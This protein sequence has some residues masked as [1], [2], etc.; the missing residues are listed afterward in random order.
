ME[1]LSHV[2]RHK[3]WTVMLAA[4]ANSPRSFRKHSAQQHEKPPAFTSPHR[5]EQR[6]ICNLGQEGYS[7]PFGKCCKF[8][9]KEQT[10]AVAA[11]GARPQH[12]SVCQHH[13]LLEWSFPDAVKLYLILLELCNTRG[14]KRKKKKPKPKN[15]P[16]LQVAHYGTT[17]PWK[18]NMLGEKQLE[19]GKRAPWWRGRWNKQKDVGGL[20]HY[21]PLSLYHTCS[22]GH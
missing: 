4:D 7:F 16:C 18:F 13:A 5:W 8:C 19:A 3:A 10:R 21:R 1:T 12:C 14:K 2:K 6:E 17:K 15:P 20:Q 9:T 11:G 22:E